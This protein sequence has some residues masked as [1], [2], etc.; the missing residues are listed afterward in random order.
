MSLKE[1]LI[2]TDGIMPDSGAV[3]V[4]HIVKKQHIVSVR[5]YIHYFFSVHSLT[6]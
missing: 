6:S 1:E 2:T 5:K 3:L 4:F